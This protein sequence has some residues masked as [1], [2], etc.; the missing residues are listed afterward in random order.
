MDLSCGV[1]RFGGL[2]VWVGVGVRKG[3]SREEFGE[4][5]MMWG[6]V[7]WEDEN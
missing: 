1:W 4:R 2:G 6:G 7:G 5:R 3:L